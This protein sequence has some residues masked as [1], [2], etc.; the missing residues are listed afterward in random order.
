LSCDIAAS[1]RRGPGELADD[2]R[3]LPRKGSKGGE[4]TRAHH[5]PDLIDAAR[6]C[7]NRH[8][9]NDGA[10]AQEQDARLSVRFNPRQRE[11]VPKEIGSR[12][13]ELRHAL[14]TQDGDARRSHESAT[15]RGG[16]DVRREQRFEPAT[17]PLLAAAMNA[18]SN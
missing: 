8:E 6:R 4:L 13:D 3:S 15:V 14:S 11:A 10:L 17:S 2:G 18:L 16:D 5:P 9:H 7:L 12:G 1:E